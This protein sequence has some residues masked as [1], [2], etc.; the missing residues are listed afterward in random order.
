MLT[1]LVVTE[2]D[3]PAEVAA[4]IGRLIEHPD[5]ASKQGQA[6][7][8]RAETEFSYDNLA[9]RLGDALSHLRVVG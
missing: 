5:L 8:A 1:G 7:R 6:A 9:T 2:P 4:G 3:D